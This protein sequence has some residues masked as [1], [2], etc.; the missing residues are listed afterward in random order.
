MHEVLPYTVVSIIAIDHAGDP[1]SILLQRRTKATTKSHHYGLWELPQ[2]KIRAGETIFESACREL[3]EESGLQALTLH[4]SHTETTY[5]DNDDLLAFS[6]LTCVFDLSN[7]CI[8]LAVIVSTTGIPHDTEEASQHQ[9]MSHD[10]VTKIIAQDELFSLNIPMVE[11]FFRLKTN[12][13]HD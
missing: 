11:N 6:P 5:H 1:Q 4:G 10:E 13:H 3:K 2:G 7:Q 8:G 12:I 9:W